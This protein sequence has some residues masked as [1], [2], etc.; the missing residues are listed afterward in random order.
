MVPNRA[1]HHICHAVFRYR[2]PGIICQNKD[3]F[4]DDQLIR[5]SVTAS[6]LAQILIQ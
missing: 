4:M 3:K 2:I 5:M 6:L 1:T